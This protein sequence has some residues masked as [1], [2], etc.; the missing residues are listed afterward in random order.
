MP[1]SARRR[2]S[3]RHLSVLCHATS[4]KHSMPLEH[5]I[6]APAPSALDAAI[7][8]QRHFHGQCVRR[9]RRDAAHTGVV[10][11]QTYSHQVAKRL[12]RSVSPVT[13]VLPRRRHYAHRAG[14]LLL[15]PLPLSPS[16]GYPR[17]V[18]R[19]VATPRYHHCVEEI[20]EK[21]QAPL[22]PPTRWMQCSPSSRTSSPVAVGAV[23]YDT[24]H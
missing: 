21:R 11:R 9:T 15:P 17:F 12:L 4:A 3:R 8:R 18:V 16:D 22:S 20:G 5:A 1:R 14:R 2:S 10:C 6:F 24:T 19:E 7:L 23:R 13:E